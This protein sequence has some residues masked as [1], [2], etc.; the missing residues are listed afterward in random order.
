VRRTLPVAAGGPWSSLVGIENS[1]STSQNQLATA[2]ATIA[3]VNAELQN[4]PANDQHTV[5]PGSQA[6]LTQELAKLMATHQALQS[7]FQ[8]NLQS[9]YDFFVAAAQSQPQTTQLLTAASHAPAAVATAVT[10]DLS[11]VQ[12]QLAQ[13]AA[14]AAAAAA[15]TAH[16]PTIPA[17]PRG[18][19][20]LS[21]Q[22]PLSGV[23]S[24]V[25]GPSQF[26]LEPPIT[27]NGVFYPHFHTGLDIA[28]PLDTP[29]GAAAT[30]TVVLAT[31]SRDAQ[32]NLVGYGNYVV[33]SH[34]DGVLSVYGHLDKLLVQ[35]GQVLQQGQEI[36]LCG[37]TGWSTGPHVHFE[38]RI[39]GNY[40]D[41]APYLA[42]AMRTR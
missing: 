40:V 13:E 29:V 22:P 21:F 42:K 26:S 34:G 36:G 10:S 8:Q 37:S 28:A 32:G 24:Q 12:T 6:R 4:A 11:L 27:Y 1:V 16:L 19:T 38:I 35:A 23:V 20:A 30:G 33:I 2:E 3:A 15:Q 18:R 25:F 5:H 31:S 41:P 9:E 39:D 7:A 17:L 14:I